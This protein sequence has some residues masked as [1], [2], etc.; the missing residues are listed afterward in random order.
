MDKVHHALSVFYIPGE[1]WEPRPVV[2]LV[3]TD[4]A[5]GGLSTR[6]TETFTL[7]LATLVMVYLLL[8]AKD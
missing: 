3:V 6:K 1:L 5:S 2:C 8:V 7:E 4:P